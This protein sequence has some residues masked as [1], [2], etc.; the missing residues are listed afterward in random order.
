PSAGFSTFN[1]FF[2]TDPKGTGLGLSITHKLLEKNN[3]FI[4]IDS[5]EEKGC[6]V[7]LIMPLADES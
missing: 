2:T 4:Y 6:Q 3:A 1:P 7:T 5:K